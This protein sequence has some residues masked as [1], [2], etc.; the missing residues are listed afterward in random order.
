MHPF[1]YETPFSPHTG[2][3][4]CAHAVAHANEGFRNRVGFAHA[5]STTKFT[6]A[7][8]PSSPLANAQFAQH[9]FAYVAAPFAAHTG[10]N[11]SSPHR[12]RHASSAFATPSPAPAA[13]AIGASARTGAGVAR[14]LRASR[15]TLASSSASSFSAVDVDIDAS[16]SRVDVPTNERRFVSRDPCLKRH[17]STSVDARARRRI[18]TR[19]R[20]A[21]EA[22][23]DEPRDRAKSARR[24]RA[25]KAMRRGGASAMMTPEGYERRTTHRT[26]TT[27]RDDDDD[28]WF[29]SR[30]TTREKRR[31]GDALQR[32]ALDS[33]WG[34]ARGKTRRARDDGSPSKTRSR[35]GATA[36]P[37]VALGAVDDA[38]DAMIVK[39]IGATSAAVSALTRG[40]SYLGEVFDR[41]A[42][43]WD[44]NDGKK[45]DDEG[46]TR[47]KFTTTN[48]RAP[49][50]KENVPVTPRAMTFGTRDDDS[51][52]LEM[53]ALRREV[54]AAKA[55]ERETT[56]LAE[57]LKRQNLALQKRQVAREAKASP[58]MVAL[59]DQLR[60]QVEALMSEKSSLTHENKR[61]Q[62]ENRDL[63]A[64]IRTSDGDE[65]D[66]DESTDASSDLG[67][68]SPEEVEKLEREIA[69]M[70]ASLENSTL[71]YAAQ[72]SSME[73]E[74]A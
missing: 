2:S 49:T 12:A 10:A 8:L 1:E 25:P 72:N 6:R 14:A 64:F 53:E 65:D 74:S 23:D 15:A 44:A 58:E 71:D 20:D 70:E 28:G 63:H 61:L 36:T 48:A 57:E 22:R 66:G 33:A 17:P 24:T 59:V 4:T 32:A 55:R 29:A 69:E 54:A 27:R 68:L 35:G 37:E 11:A 38:I 45:D 13:T 62:R 56:R 16:A 52:A 73:S 40:A 51:S 50:G 42:D 7:P 3:Y 67:N 47:T 5:P 41:A 19:A 43:S 46:W 9:L 18:A 60:A 21:R 31:D 34:G 39:S 26:P 30:T